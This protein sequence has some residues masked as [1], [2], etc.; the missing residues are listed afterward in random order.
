MTAISFL[1][2][3]CVFAGLWLFLRALVWLRQGRIDWR[4]EALLLL[5]Y[6]NLAVILRFTF[7]P[8]NRVD[9]QVQP[10]LF[11]PDAILP[12]RVNLTPITHI[13]RYRRK[14]DIL[15]NVY[16]NIFLFLPTGFILPLVYKRLDRFWKVVAAGAGLSLCIE[17]LQLPFSVRSTDIDDLLLNTLGVALGFALY[18]LVSRL[19]KKAAH[20]KDASN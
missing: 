8:M 13:L 20:K 9:G 6:V 12:F 15:L 2:G 18:A 3:E 5:M 1:T 19:G 7:F 14:R 10:L 17:L 4:R 11:K 16:G